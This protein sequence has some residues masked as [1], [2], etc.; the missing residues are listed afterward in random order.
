MRRSHLLLAGA[1][2]VAGVASLVG[3]GS[4]SAP[5]EVQGALLDPGS[6]GNPDPRGAETGPG[7]R[8]EPRDPGGALAPVATTGSIA[9][10]LDL[11]HRALAADG[12]HYE[13][14]FKDGRRAVL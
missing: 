8:G 1:V 4:R 6:R 10:L 3:A 14:P 12:A 2:T 11:D 5:A 7:G 9:D 13:A